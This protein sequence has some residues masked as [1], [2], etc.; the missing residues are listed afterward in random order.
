MA[1]VGNA[2]F[3]AEDAPLSVDV[4][5]NVDVVNLLAAGLFTAALP[6]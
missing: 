1:A 4:G 2:A 6:P 3:A 5:E